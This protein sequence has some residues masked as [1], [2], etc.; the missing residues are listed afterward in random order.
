MYFQPRSSLFGA[1]SNVPG[2]A[3]LVPFLSLV[4]LAAISFRNLERTYESGHLSLVRGKG[5]KKEIDITDI[6]TIGRDE[7][8]TLGLF[9]DNAIDQH[10]AEVKKV[11]GRYIV[12]D[13]AGTGTFVNRERVAGKREL[14]DGDVIEIGETRI[15]FSE[16]TRQACGSCGS[17]V[18]VNAKFCPTC[19]VK[20]A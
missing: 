14:R 10:H 7:R 4:G 1:G 5:T 11:D 9:K 2:W 17:T 15:V 6:V 12:E 19:G 20:A 3:W 13:K 8:N 18:R 16:G